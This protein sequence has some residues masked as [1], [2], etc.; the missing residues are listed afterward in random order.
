MI[1]GAPPMIMSVGMMIDSIKHQIEQHNQR[2]EQLHHNR[3]E[4]QSKL[5]RCQEEIDH[6]EEWNRQARSTLTLL[7]SVND[8]TS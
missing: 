4:L 8:S 6:Y 2:I 3:V 1:D 5:N 7:E